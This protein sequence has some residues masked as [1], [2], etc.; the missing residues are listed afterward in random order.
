MERSVRVAK[1]K[2]ITTAVVN[3]GDV[4]Y[5]LTLQEDGLHRK[6]KWAR[7]ET[8]ISLSQLATAEVKNG[9]CGISN[10]A[11]KADSAC[12]HLDVAAQDL[13]T[14]ARQI[15]ERDTQG[16]SSIALVKVSLL[17]ALSIVRALDHVV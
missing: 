2:R 17:K 13:Q 12:E 16:M 9:A 10:S 15:H 3:L 4:E 6:R 5:T 8:V 7:D 14:L 1:H 11:Y